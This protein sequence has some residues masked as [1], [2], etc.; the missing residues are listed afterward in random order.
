MDN[1]KLELPLAGKGSGERGVVSAASYE[2]RKFGIRAFSRYI[3]KE[4]VS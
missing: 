4:D 1:P 2:A 3:V